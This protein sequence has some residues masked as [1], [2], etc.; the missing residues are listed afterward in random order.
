MTAPN[1]SVGGR[2]GLHASWPEVVQRPCT[3]AARVSG[4]QCQSARG[5]EDGG[6]CWG[7][8]FTP[9]AAVHT[10]PPP[11]TC[12]HLPQQ[13]LSAPA[14]AGAWGRG[15]PGPYVPGPRVHCSRLDHPAAHP[16]GL[17]RSQGGVDKRTIEKY[18][19]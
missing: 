8:P 16:P 17:P 6:G 4:W 5:G 1:K 7:R 15:V 11:H 3:A 2:K 13:C 19:R 10:V 14:P 18:E 12:Q 9:H